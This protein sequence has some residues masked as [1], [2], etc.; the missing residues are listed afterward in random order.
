MNRYHYYRNLSGEDKRSSRVCI[1]SQRPETPVGGDCR[2]ECRGLA[3]VYPPYQYFRQLY[4]P[5][6]ALKRGTLFSEL[7]LPFVGKGGNR[8]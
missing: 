3:T 7:D 8:K 4:L 6:A 2:L 5:E 1:S